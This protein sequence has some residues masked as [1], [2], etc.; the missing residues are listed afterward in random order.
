MSYPSQPGSNNLI[1]SSANS[2][3]GSGS[4]VWQ[5]RNSPYQNVAANQISGLGVTAYKRLHPPIIT[6]A[7]TID[8]EEGLI[9]YDEDSERLCYTDSTLTWRC[10][11]LIDEIP[12]ATTFDFMSAVLLTT[13][14]VTS[15]V[16]GY[17]VPNTGYKIVTDWTTTA[18]FVASTNWNNATGVYTAVAAGKF[19]VSAQVSWKETFKNQGA[20]VLRIMHETSLGAKTIMVETVTNP[21]PNKSVNTVQNAS[22]GITM[23]VGDK[24][25]LEVSQTS[26]VVKEVEGGATLG[27]S[28][29]VIQIQ[30]VA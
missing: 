24:I 15:A 10:L 22:T 20:R 6:N 1:F 26:G 18:P 3:Q 28:G 2:G 29:T 27:S 21:S 7:D 12:G 8:R 17:G 30:K 25:Y 19:K 16:P 4:S 23:A 5:Y 14:S 13:N 11:A 9:A